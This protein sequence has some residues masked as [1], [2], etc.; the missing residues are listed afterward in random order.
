MTDASVRRRSGL[1]A[2]RLATSIVA[3]LFLRMVI[4]ASGPTERSFIHFIRPVP[5]G[6]SWLVTSLWLVTTI[7]VVAL[8]AISALIAS[9]RRV[10]IDL[11][12][13]AG[14]ALLISFLMNKIL[15]VLAIPGVTDISH[16][17]PPIILSCSS[18]ATLVALPY[19]SR[20]VQRL[21]E[22]MIVVAALTALL[23]GSGLPLA[24]IAAIM[25]GWG[26]A[27]LTRLIWGSPVGVEP[28]GAVAAGLAQLGITGVSVTADPIQRW[29]VSSYL[30]SDDSRSLRVSLYGRDA[31]ES[32]LLAKIYRSV[33]MRDQAGSFAFTR[34]QQLEHE[35]YLTLLFRSAIG[36]RSSE[37]VASGFA[38]PSKDAY[39][40]T[41]PPTGATLRQMQATIAELSDDTLV[42]MA[43]MVF[44]I[45]QADL[46]HGEIGLDALMV[47][48]DSVGIQDLGKAVVHASSADVQ[49]DVASLMVTLALATDAQRSLAAV[50]SAFG[51]DAVKA[52]LAYLQ[53][54]ALPV[55]LTVDLRRA[56]EHGLLKQ[57]REQGAA[58]VGVET[59][60][61]AKLRR[62]GGMQIVLA[63]GTIIGGWALIGVLLKVVGAWST[64]TH[65]EW[66][67]VIVTALIAQLAYVSSAFATLGS[68]T[69]TVPLKPLI[70]LELSNTFSGLA[71]GTPA[72]LAARVRFFQK[73]GVDTTEAVSSG[74]LESTASWIVKG[75]L[76]LI[77]IPFA[78]STIHVHDVVG[79]QAGKGASSHVMHLLVLVLE[80]VVGLGVVIAIAM[81]I[82]RA[83]KLAK[84]KLAPKFGE[85]RDHLKTLAKR[86]SKMLSIFGGT[87]GAQL[88]TAFAL[89]TA[90]MSFHQHLALPVI[91]VVLTFGSIL[92][93]ISPVPGGMGVVETGMIIGL[94]ACGIDA[95]A[96]VAAVFV[97]RLFTA[98]LP[99]MA[100]WVCLMWLRRKS[101]L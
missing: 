63:V 68:I 71:L 59:P 7:G 47:G 72:V 76:L 6:L 52:A 15:G 20:A 89:S 5:L 88:V 46:A 87:A 21:L 17:Y 60:E 98:Y 73:R 84:S 16:A 9:Q 10:V 57:L 32:Q 33:M 49:R 93:G 40:V 66:A 25:L 22:I 54:A 2:L 50:S 74:V 31:R 29:G 37:L 83:R 18:A 3:L 69:K 1:D 101:Y 70:V 38:G 64:L 77:S 39:C 81:F 51:K 41:Q 26:V 65:A 94:K 92:G 11:A 100:G 61:L 30:A 53:E 13:A 23:H 44:D 34:A 79:A 96:A 19:L 35:S 48:P 58:L 85:V 95:D 56:K 80:I 97:Q 62:V 12:T 86:P 91:I 24:L 14:I 4:I 43:K 90:L 27:S 75:A 67:W 36:Q 99:P 8:L 42:E 28:D 78:L 82:P 55:R 45:H